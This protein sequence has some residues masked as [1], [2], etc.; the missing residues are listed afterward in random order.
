MYRPKGF[1]ML[2][3]PADKRELYTFRFCWHKGMYNLQSVKE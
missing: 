3:A 1:S 2:I